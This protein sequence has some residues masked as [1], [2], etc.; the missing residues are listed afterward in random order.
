MLTLTGRVDN[1]SY[2]GYI[3]V[4]MIL[5]YIWQIPQGLLVE[6]HQ[7]IFPMVD[8]KDKTT[9]FFLLSAQESDHQAVGRRPQRWEQ[10]NWSK[11]EGIARVATGTQRGVGKKIPTWTNNMQKI[12]RWLVTS[13]FEIFVL[14]GWKGEAFIVFIGSMY[15]IFTII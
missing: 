3:Y 10:F 13:S 14:L 15:G 9:L 1:P 8:S 2:Y 12:V 6:F 4:F 11:G 7:N 5:V